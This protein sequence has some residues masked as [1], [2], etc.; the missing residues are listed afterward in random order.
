MKVSSRLSLKS[1]WQKMSV[2]T[3]IDRVLQVSIYG[4]FQVRPEVWKEQIQT[5][6]YEFLKQTKASFE[7]KLLPKV[8]LLGV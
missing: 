3:K 7:D 5:R 4:C 2:T 6:E 1:A 8:I